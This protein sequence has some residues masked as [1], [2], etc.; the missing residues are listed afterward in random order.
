MRLLDLMPV[1]SPQ[2]RSGLEGVGRLRL[3]EHPLQLVLASTAPIWDGHDPGRLGRRRRRLHS[4]H[5]PGRCCSGG[6][7]LVDLGAILQREMRG[8]GAVVRMQPVVG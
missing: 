5:R 1:A 6:I 2:R 4:R 3:I 8:E 7:D